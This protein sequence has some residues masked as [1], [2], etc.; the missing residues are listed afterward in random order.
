MNYRRL[1]IHGSYVFLTVVTY[2]RKKILTENIELLR[3]SFKNA[4]KYFN[5]EIIAVVILP[6]HFHILLKP[7][8]IADY[9]KIITSIK[10]YFSRRFSVV[11]QECP[12]YKLTNYKKHE[13]IYPCP[14]YN[15]A[16]N[17]W[18]R[19]FFEHTIRDEKD[20]NNHLDYIHYNPVKHNYVEN[21]SNWEFSSFH[22]FVKYGNYEQNWRCL[23]NME[24]LKELKINKY[25]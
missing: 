15:R 2:N 4:K 17:I 10:F 1:F 9:P 21:T 11:G 14:T 12:T 7:E 25:D 22:K 5:F 24:N 20:L 3:N 18:Q 19:R 6:D 23:N 16:K 13:N 8:N